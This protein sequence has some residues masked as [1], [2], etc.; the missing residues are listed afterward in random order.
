M[1]FFWGGRVAF[2]L[3]NLNIIG[4]YKKIT[5]RYIRVGVM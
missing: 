2:S 5:V 1:L 3:N 4:N